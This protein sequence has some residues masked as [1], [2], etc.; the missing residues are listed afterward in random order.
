[1][2][3]TT[4]HIRVLFHR[5]KMGSWNKS[6]PLYWFFA[7]TLCVWGANAAHWTDQ[8]AV[9]IP[10]GKAVADIV[11]R[12]TGFINLGEVCWIVFAF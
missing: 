9:N 3:I 12:E 4:D 10:G 7:L 2:Y 6:S 11:A 1:M 8:W 5:Q